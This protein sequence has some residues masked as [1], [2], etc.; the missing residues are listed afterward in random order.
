MPAQDCSGAKNK[1]DWVEAHI[2][3]A[4]G[5]GAQT[6]LDIAYNYCDK[7]EREKMLP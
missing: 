7:D 5:E 1:T 4:T 6:K 2:S 3:R